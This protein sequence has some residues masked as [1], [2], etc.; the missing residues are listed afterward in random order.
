[1]RLNFI[2]CAIKQE[3]VPHK[4]SPKI[5]LRAARGKDSR[6]LHTTRHWRCVFYNFVSLFLFIFSFPLFGIW[7]VTVISR[8]RMGTLPR[9]AS[10]LARDSEPPWSL[11]PGD[12]DS[13]GRRQYAAVSIDLIYMSK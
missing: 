12:T 3:K 1:M 10:S 11:T 13:G 8:T 5:L 9:G 7:S 4:T 6:R 2:G